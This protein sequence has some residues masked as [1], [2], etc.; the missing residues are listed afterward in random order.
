VNLSFTTN[1]QKTIHI[2]PFPS[3]RFKQFCLLWLQMYVILIFSLKILRCNY[4]RLCHVL[5]L[6]KITY[7]LH[8][9]PEC[10]SNS[11]PLTR[12]STDITSLVFLALIYTEHSAELPITSCCFITA[13]SINRAYSAVRPK[14]GPHFSSFLILFSRNL[15]T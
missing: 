6:V 9:I 12:S 13:H 8:L 14:I 2:L 15:I 7:T 10:K 3:S 11:I 4:Y 1:V 5:N